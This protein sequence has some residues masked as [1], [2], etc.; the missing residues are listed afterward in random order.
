MVNTSLYT[1]LSGMRAHQRYLDVIGN[2]VA[3]VSTV[4]F[5]GSRASFSDI[6]SYTIRP[7]SGPEGLFGGENPLQIGLGTRVSSIDLNTVQGTFT[8][9]G[10]PL[11]VA[12][13]GKGFFTLTDGVQ[14][15]FTRAGAFGIDGDR[16][17]VDLRT[18]FRVQNTSGTTITVPVSDTLPP[19]ATSEIKFQGNLPAVVSGPL[20]EILE[21]VAAF[22]AG[23]AATKTSNPPGPGTT[24]DISAFLDRTLLVAVNGGAQQTVTFPASVFGAGTNVSASAI[25]ARF[26]SV[27]GLTATANNGTGD[28]VFDT[29]KLGTAATLKFDDGAGATGFLT[30]LGLNATLVSGTQSAATAATNLSSLVGRNSAYV[31]GDRITVSG[32]N[33]NSTAVSDTFVYGTNGTTLGDLITF[34]NATFDSAQVTAALQ[35]NGM[36]RMTAT[37]KQPANLSLFIGDATGNTGSSTW[38]NFKVIQDGKGPDTATTSID[39]IDSLGRAHAVKMTFT[40]TIAD[41]NVWDMQATMDAAE[42]TIPS[43][44]IGTIRFNS[45]GSFNVIGGGNNALTFSFAGI[46]AAQTVTINLGT[47][48]QYDGVAMLGNKATVAATDQD[49]YAAGTLLNVAFDQE[50][51]L[52]GYYSNGK[53]K[54]FA[55]LRISVFPNE[56]GLLRAG[57]TLFVQSPNSDDPIATTAVAA[58]AGV[59]RAGSLENSNVDIAQEFVSLIEA[60]RG[61]QANSRVITT[62][63]EMLAELMNIVR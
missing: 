1:G 17:L 55:Q 28:I 38:P 20:E 12:I 36:L 48:G 18:G 62:T 35:T 53:T 4:G 57:D 49:G 31:N 61:F 21:S 60:Q 26:A 24:Y 6:L 59:I 54:E 25:A 63:D 52:L 39:V 44:T 22:Q 27:T 8:D 46:A 42:G 40:R 19:Q 30:Q 34:I 10:R 33:P 56:G 15:Y 51:K 37:Q 2:N 9:T 58:G 23:T 5:W 3:N 29:V 50:G 47:S 13:Q 11:D 41:P 7:G 43:A 14:T 32:T 16:S 45:D